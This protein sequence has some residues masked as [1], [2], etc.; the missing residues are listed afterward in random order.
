M[1]LVCVMRVRLSNELQARANLTLD[2]AEQIDRQVEARAE[3]FPSLGE[4]PLS[5]QYTDQSHISKT[6]KEH[7]EVYKANLLDRKICTDV[8]IVATSLI[9][10]INA[11]LVVLIVSSTKRKDFFRQCAGKD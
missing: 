6:Q 9:Q 3:N 11:Q 10:N 4:R 8:V 7:I 2:F 1:L 5:M